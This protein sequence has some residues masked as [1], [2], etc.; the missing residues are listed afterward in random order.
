M[1]YLIFCYDEV[2]DEVYEADN[3]EEAYRLYKEIKPDIM[4][5]DIH[6]PKLNGLELLKKLGKMI[7]LLEQS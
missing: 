6:I 2:Y 3:G 7:I 5:I 1:L 4:I